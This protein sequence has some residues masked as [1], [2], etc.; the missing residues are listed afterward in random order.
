[1]LSLE[2]FSSA[3]EANFC[4]GSF[5]SMKEYC[6]AVIRQGCSPIL[7]KRRVY[8]VLIDATG[9][10]GKQ[11]EALNICREVLSKLGH[12]FPNRA[13]TLHVLA[14][15]VKI[16]SKLKKTTS[17]EL[18]ARLPTLE[19]PA[20]QWAMA[21]I[22]KTV[23]WAYHTQ[24]DILPLSIFKGLQMTMKEGVSVYSP[25]MFVLVGFLLSGVVFDFQ[26]GAAFGDQAI[27]LLKKVKGA[28]KVESRVQFI[29]H[30]FSFCWVRPISL[31]IKPLIASYETGLATGDTESASFSVYFALE[32]QFRTGTPLA[33]L[34]ADCAFYA[35]QLREVKMFKILALLK[36]LWQSA[37]FLSGVNEFDGTLTGEIVQQAPELAGAG[38][39]HDYLFLAIHRSLM[40]VQFALGKHRLVYE[41]IKKTE[42]DNNGY[43]KGFPGIAGKWHLRKDSLT[44]LFLF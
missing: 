20:K 3:A 15:I 7:D 11:L 23:T 41:S 43:E 4:T 2:L 34:I 5:E 35:E 16:K 29:A 30:S 32:Y 6:D 25:I 37:L 40:Y 18:V 31:S 26:G 8:M 19:D 44:V 1:V 24:S 14:G 39:F 28:R 12:R 17:H 9:A 13:V 21:M 38:D 27:E 42:M 33:T 36:N 10:A 22:D